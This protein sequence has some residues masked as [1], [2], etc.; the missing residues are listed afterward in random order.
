VI[1]INEDLFIKH[2]MNT[3]KELED[4]LKLINKKGF[5][6][7][8]KLVDKVLTLYSL[9]LENL[10]YAK[11]NYLD[12]NTY[13]YLNEL[14]LKAHNTI[15]IKESTRKN[16]FI[17]FFTKTFKEYFYKYK[18]YILAAFLIFTFGGIIAYMLC[19]YN[20][21]NIYAFLPKSFVKS[22]NVNGPKYVDSPLMSSE[23]MTNNIKVTFLA[24]VYGITVGILTFYILF[25]NGAMIGALLA[26]VQLNH[27]SMLKSIS[28]LTPHGFIELFAIF[29]SGGCGL[30]IGLSI[31]H[32]KEFTR[33]NAIKYK[34]K[35]SMYLMLGVIIMLVIA[36]TIEGFV[37]PSHL[38]PTAK[39]IF[40]LLTA[41]LMFI[42]L[43]P[44]KFLKHK[45]KADESVKTY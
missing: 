37:T 18:Y 13:L 6:N 5:K 42:Y 39:I 11:T 41:L 22:I 28:L 12:S 9:V 45:S 17:N 24:F 33:L 21:N 23:I 2:N 4:T 20:P 30:M 16:S 10:S 1:I 36:G 34:A 43:V 44:K 38:S 14:T 25:Q 3:W 15:Y 29:I 40:G 26:Y 7:N 27:Q 32:P 8:K 19:L 31:I 35:D